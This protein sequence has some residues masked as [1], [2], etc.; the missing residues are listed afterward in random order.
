MF[1]KCKICHR[2]V[3]GTEK[4]YE[5][6]FYPVSSFCFG[7]HRITTSKPEPSFIPDWDD[8]LLIGDMSENQNKKITIS[9]LCELLKKRL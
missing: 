7:G 3:L 5:K 8:V 9:Q 2:T 4:W 6:L 1:M